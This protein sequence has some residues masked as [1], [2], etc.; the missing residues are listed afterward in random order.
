VLGWVAE[1]T[2]DQEWGK[3]EKGRWGKGEEGKRGRGEEG[4]AFLITFSFSPSRP[5]GGGK[6]KIQNS[7]FLIPHS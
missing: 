6:F 5:L 4:T 1:Q 2:F 7:K 3:G